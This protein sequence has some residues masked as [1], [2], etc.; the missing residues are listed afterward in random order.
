MDEIA[1]AE[2]VLDELVGGA[3]VRHAQQRLGQH[4]QCEALL[5]RERELPQHVL[6][7]AKPVVA[8][9]D[10]LDQRGLRLLAILD[11]MRDELDEPDCDRSHDDERRC[12]NCGFFEQC[13]QAIGLED[14]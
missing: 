5:G 8:L 13:D 9:A 7:P 11:E 14:V 10:R 2:L 1:L 12:L 4:H 6:D 3:R